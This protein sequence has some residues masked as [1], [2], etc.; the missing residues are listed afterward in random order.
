MDPEKRQLWEE[1]I[2]NQ[3]DSGLS[4]RR[5][6]IEQQIE[7]RH[8]YYWKNRLYPRNRKFTLLE[9]KAEKETGVIT[10]I[11]GNT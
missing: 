6:C 5:W 4:I 8:Y 2:K 7:P 1:R 3:N 10:W 11:P 9:L